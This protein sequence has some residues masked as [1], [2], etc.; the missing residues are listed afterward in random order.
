[1]I[2][3]EVAF[4][5]V[6]S[7]DVLFV[8][9]DSPTMG[10]AQESLRQQLP[11]MMERLLTGVRTD[12]ETVDPIRDLHVAVISS[13]LGAHNVQAAAPGCGGEPGG[14]GAKLLHAANG[15]GCEDSYPSFLSARSGLPTLHPLIEL[16]PPDATELGRDLACIGTLGNAGCS[17]RQPLEAALAALS[18]TTA[19][20]NEGFLRNDPRTGLSLIVVVVIADGDDCSVA[21]QSLFE[22]GRG[23]LSPA[24]YCADE[25]ERLQTIER[26]VDGLRALRPGNEQLVMFAAL[27]GVPVDAANDEARAA[28]VPDDEASRDAFY[29]AILAHPHMQLLVEPGGELRPAC[30]T[31]F[32]RARPAQ[33]LLEV[34]RSF[35]QNGTVRSICEEDWTQV[36][37]DLPL[38]P[39]VFF[40]Q[41]GVCLPRPMPRDGEGLVPCTVT[42]ELPPP[43]DAPPGSPTTCEE[44]SSLSPHPDRA[45]GDRGG[46]LCVVRQLAVTGLPE[47][48]V[49]ES[50]EGW[51]YDDFSLQV[52]K[53]CANEMQRALFF[54]PTLPPNGVSVAIEC[55]DERV[56]D[57]GPGVCGG[58]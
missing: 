4:T 55:I 54:A 27:T 43:V 11:A 42:W 31:R 15:E 29:D 28:L 35:G 49:L 6:D 3:A 56:A 41:G 32:A 44:R 24:A 2:T 50:G 12:G 20:A 7:V 45:K 58:P 40:Q 21:D 17:Y 18:G 48:P 33:R 8:I 13:D 39:D 14:D 9:D 23:A 34:A 19:T 26:Y 46:A 37:D 51:F 38:E 30:D 52:R 57:G 36:F 22:R 25:A 1:V 5:H 47:D 16:A 53:Q 10:A